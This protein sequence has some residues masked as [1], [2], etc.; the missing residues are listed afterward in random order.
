MT[1]Y[2]L[3]LHQPLKLRGNIL[4]ISRLKMEHKSMELKKTQMK[5]IYCIKCV[6][7]RSRPEKPLAPQSYGLCCLRAFSRGNGGFTAKVCTDPSERKTESTHA[8][9]NT[10]TQAPGSP[11]GAKRPQSHKT[12]EAEKKKRRRKETNPLF[13]AA[14]TQNKRTQSLHC[15]SVVSQHDFLSFSPHIPVFPSL[16]S[17]WSLI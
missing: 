16:P 15:P 12:P 9:A 7:A 1:C 3:P 17:S 8:R 4:I 5:R 10:Q 14:T 13:H 11:H 2:H 6:R